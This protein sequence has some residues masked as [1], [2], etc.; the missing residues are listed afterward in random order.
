MISHA[1]EGPP[2]PPMRIKKA[3]KIRLERFIEDLSKPP[4]P[5]A[6]EKAKK[7]QAPKAPEKPKAPKTPKA[8]KDLAQKVALIHRLSL[9]AKES[10]LQKG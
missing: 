10:Q 2:I 4:P 1:H 8:P 5:E 3:E 7:L 6:L 9:V